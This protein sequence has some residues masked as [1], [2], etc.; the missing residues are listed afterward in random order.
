MLVTMFNLSFAGEKN[1]NYSSRERL[2]YIRKTFF[3]ADKSL[4][5][6]QLSQVGTALHDPLL[7]LLLL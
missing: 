4:G 7:L 5:K 1:G 6:R 2:D 3:A